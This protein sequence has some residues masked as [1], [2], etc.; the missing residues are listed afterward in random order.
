MVQDNP[1]DPKGDS[2]ETRSPSPFAEKSADSAQIWPT[3]KAEA[4]SQRDLLNRYAKS[5]DSSALKLPLL[6]DLTLQKADTA[7]KATEKVTAA[8]ATPDGAKFSR[9]ADY[10]LA[11]LTRKDGSTVEINYQDGKKNQIIDTSKDG[12]SRTIYTLN[13]KGGWDADKQTKDAGG[14]FQSDKKSGIKYRDINI[15]DNGITKAVD[16]VGFNHVTMPDGTQLNPGA[17]YT[18]DEKGRI[19]SIGYMPG[20]N[21]NVRLHYDANNKIDRVETL[22]DEG[23]LQ[24]TRSKTAE[25]EWT[26][27][28][29]GSSAGTKWQ[30]DIEV[31]KEGTFKQRDSKDRAAGVWDVITPFEQFKERQSPDGRQISR[32]YKNGKE[33]DYVKAENGEERITKLTR[34]KESREFRYDA[35]G[36]LLELTD[37]TA[38]GR[39]TLRTEEMLASIDPSGATTLTRADG[40]KISK[41]ADFSSEEQD[42]DGNISRVGTKDGRSRSFDYEMVNNQ[43]LLVRITDSKPDPKGGQS[44]EV[45]NRKKN[46]D[47][48][49]TNEF[50]AVLAGGKEKVARSVEVLSNGDYKY[51]T[52]DGKEQIAKVSDSNRSSG[53]SG[54]VLEARERLL[55]SLDGQ[56]DAARKSR[57]ETMMKEFEKRA[58]TAVERQSI[59][60]GNKDAITEKWE[61]KIAK[62][63]DHLAQ[64]MEENP[65]TAVYNQAM[66][67]KLVENFLWISADTTRGAQDVGNCWELSGRNLTG[68]Q[69]NPDSM[70]RM[71]KEVSLTGTFTAVHGGMKSKDSLD[72]RKGDLDAAKK[73]TIP[74][75]MLQLD[76]VNAGWSI[77]KPN[78]SYWQ[79]GIGTMPSTPVGYILDNVLGYMGGRK[80]HAQLDGGTWESF[81]SPSGNTREGWYHGIN[82][83]MYMA[84]GERTA[85]PVRVASNDITDGDIRNLTD[86]RLQK[87]LLEN[88]GALLLGPGHMFAVKL[89]KNAGEWQIVTDNQWGTGGDQVIGRVTDLRSWNVQTTRVKYKNN[90]KNLA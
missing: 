85:K 11:K 24:Q 90:N 53:F 9:N 36:K 5:S 60:G 69:N 81:P 88:G 10:T 35:Q 61:K 13:P 46:P 1:R 71:L 25:G 67:A 83:L 7:P 80:S 37:T 59:A 58:E 39:Q 82:E 2:P 76:R 54:G 65:S 34:G 19:A 87:Q 55:A 14:S 29:R 52:A 6:A 56:L 38:S 16:M 33:I 62:T 15:D 63:Y 79:G 43:K 42:K 57:L 12:S 30:G 64:M 68:M 20:E 47:G 17:R 28:T 41:K 40:S 18:F 44:S 45:L 66:R 51:N 75:N 32:S 89:V 49:Y 50:F 23:K 21:R 77:D 74:K 78:D 84:T 48:N 26:V 22:D 4:D 31:T 70:A 27:T 72:R 8:E 3:N 73:F 86:K